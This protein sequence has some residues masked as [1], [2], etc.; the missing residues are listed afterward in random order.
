MI[1]KY[2]YSK[3]KCAKTTFISLWLNSEEICFLQQYHITF[4]KRGE[5]YQVNSDELKTLFVN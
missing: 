3:V 4:Y 5:F 2:L 1:S